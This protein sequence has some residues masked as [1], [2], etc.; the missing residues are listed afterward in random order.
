[1][2]EIVIGDLLEY[3]DSHDEFYYDLQN[4]CFLKAEENVRYP[5]SRYVRVWNLDDF[6]EYDL[7]QQFIENEV[8]GEPQGWL[9]NAI[10]G[11]GAFHRFRVTLQRFRMYG[12]WDQYREMALERFARRWCIENA[13]EFASQDYYDDD[14]YSEEKEEIHEPVRETAPV[15]TIAAIGE[16]N[17]YAITYMAAEFRRYLAS[18][19]HRTSD[20]DLQK[21]QEEIQYYLDRHYPIFAVSVNGKY[22]GY[23]VCRTDEKTV[24]LES[25]FVREEYRRKGYGKLLFDHCQQTAEQ[26]GNDTLYVSVHP[27]NDLMISFLKQQGYDVLNLIEIRRKYHGESEDEKA[28]IQVGSHTFRY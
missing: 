15:V 13:L 6:D 14:D 25:F 18:L 8:S 17:S 23:A 7:M 22:V 4:D 21:A 19:E 16:K 11:K 12:Q 27:N 3:I 24:F 28:D 2:T 20:T 10:R 5:E 1:M 26:L 9:R